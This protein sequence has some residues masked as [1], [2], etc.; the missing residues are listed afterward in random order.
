MSAPRLWLC[1]A[2]CAFNHWRTANKLL[3][4]SSVR[5]TPGHE[6]TA[7]PSVHMT[8]GHAH[9]Q[10]STKVIIY[11]YFLTTSSLLSPIKSTMYFR[12]G[13]R[14]QQ[15]SISGLSDVCDGVCVS[16]MYVF[17][18]IYLFSCSFKWFSFFFN[19]HFSFLF[20]PSLQKCSNK[21]QKL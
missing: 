16:V 8:N 1:I 15:N 12:N 7:Q 14:A 18:L 4:I 19:L 2:V 6:H 21:I 17:I 10:E 20:L 11:I 3:I 5:S 13:L 9:R